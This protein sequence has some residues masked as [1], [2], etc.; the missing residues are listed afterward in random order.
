MNKNTLITVGVLVAVGG[1][2]YYFYQKHKAAQPVTVGNA[3]T[4]TPSNGNQQ[5]RNDGVAGTITA[6]STAAG[7]VTDEL[8]NIG[9]AFG[10][11]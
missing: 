8:S 4:S 3:V 11:F 10:G 9:N 7:A 5:Q 6:V 2:A 1:V